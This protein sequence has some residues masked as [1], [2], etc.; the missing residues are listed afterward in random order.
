MAS[1]GQNELIIQ[2]CYQ[3]YEGSAYTYLN[4]SP[5]FSNILNDILYKV[6]GLDTI[7]NI[8]DLE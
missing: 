4:T 5:L 1:L 3:V 7:S 2:L 8:I 6:V